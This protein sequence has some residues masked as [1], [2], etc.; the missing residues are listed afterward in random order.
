VSLSDRLNELKPKQTGLPCSLG[1]SLSQM[2]ESDKKTLEEVLFDP[3]RTLSNVQL[4]E[5][6]QG[7]GYD[8]TY[9]SVS[10]HRRKACRCFIGRAPRLVKSL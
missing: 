7:E 9:S 6:L 3:P 8:V 4:V 1:K 5:A 2:D 10:L